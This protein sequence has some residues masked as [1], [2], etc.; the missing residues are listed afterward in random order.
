[1][2]ADPARTAPATGTARTTE[3][4]SRVRRGTLSRLGGRAAIGLLLSVVLALSGEATSAWAGTVGANPANC[5]TGA[6][7]SYTDFNVDGITMREELR[8]AYGCGGVGWGRL[9][10]V[11]GS[12]P[13]LALTQSAWNVGGPSQYGVPGTNWTY[14]VD[15]SA[16]HQ[17][18]AGFQ[19]YSVD[20][21]G[22]RHYIGWFYAGCYSV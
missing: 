20:E 1:M 13:A 7:W 17:V 18:C 19:A 9:S 21:F 2:N 4:T 12:G 3:P 15:A 5:G 8:H 22:T 11:G 16:G 14:T 6:T 10:Q